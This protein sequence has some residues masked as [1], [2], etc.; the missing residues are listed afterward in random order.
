MIARLTGVLL[1]KR[2]PWL[3][4]DVAGVAYELEAPMSTFYRL[5]ECG[6]AVVLRTHL[7]V[8]EDAHLLYGFALEGERRLFRELLKVNGVG[9]RLALAMLSGLEPEA[10]VAA[11]QAGEVNRLVAIPG[12]GRKTAERL[13][14]ELRDRIG[15]GL[16]GVPV[17]VPAGV[18]APVGGEE[19]PVADAVAALIALGYKPVEASR[20]VQA[21]AEP[22]M[23]REAL[24][25]AAL[26]ALMPS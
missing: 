10:L 24:I 26:K 20:Y 2:P 22:G 3:V 11:V 4:V 5:P 15:A 25:R 16:E 13:I 1:E 7:V 17:A 19:D 18:P 14:V 23:S 21:A 9:A 8:R 12:I 6:E